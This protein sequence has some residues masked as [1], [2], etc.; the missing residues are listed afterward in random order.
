MPS[1]TCRLPVESLRPSARIPATF[2]QPLPA[3]G[4]EA[5]AHIAGDKAPAGTPEDKVPVPDP[6]THT[7][8]G[9]LRIVLRP[10]AASM[11]SATATPAASVRNG[12]T[13]S[14]GRSSAE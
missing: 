3:A 4:P 11:P 10:V 9:H 1:T 12:K 8:L 5:P 6:A 13:D 7:S 14:T 2:F